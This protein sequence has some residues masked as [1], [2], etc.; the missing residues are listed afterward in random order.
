MDSYEQHSKLRRPYLCRCE[1]KF[2]TNKQKDERQSSSLKQECG[3]VK[4]LYVYDIGFVD[5]IDL[6]TIRH[7]LFDNIE[8]IALAN[9]KARLCLTRKL[10]K[11][12]TKN[13]RDIPKNIDLKNLNV[14]VGLLEV[15]IEKIIKPPK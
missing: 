2:K 9:S 3:N 8:T 7:V 5:P 6:S 1:G 12:I 4:E 10:N 13:L 11:L 15:V 14:I